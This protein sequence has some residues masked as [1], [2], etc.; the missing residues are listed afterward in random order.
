MRDRTKRRGPYREALSWRDFRA[1]FVASAVSI[2]GSVVSAVALTLLVY[3]RT[4]SP[5][6]S[7]LTFA[8]G[9]L[10]YLFGGTLLSGI[11][12]RVAPRRLL[13]GLDLAS[14]ALVAT[15]AVPAV[16]VAALLILLA[17]TSVLNSVASGARGGLVRAVVPEASYVPATS[18]LRIV[19]QAAQVL[20]NAVGGLLLAVLGARGAILVDA[21][22][23]LLSACVMRLGLRPH[24][25]LGAAGRPGVVR[26]SL[27]GVRT[28]FA[29]PRV[30]RLLLFG[31]L[32]PAFSVAPEALAASYVTRTGASPAFV[33]WWLVAL[34]VG[35]IAG[36]LL[37]VWVLPA[38]RLRRSVGIAAV[39]SLAPYLVFVARPTVGVAIP[40]LVLAGLGGMYSLGLAAL[41][42]E[43]APEEGFGRM[44]ALSTA[45]L[46]TIQGV[47]FAAAGALAEAVGPA[48]AIA[49]AGLCGILGIVLLRPSHGRRGI[50][51]TEAPLP[52]GADVPPVQGQGRA[53][54]RVV[55]GAG[56]S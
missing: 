19:V 49:I 34:P 27:R 30:R 35:M 22:S 36:D 13:V 5:L 25:I 2:T 46:M 44:M 40:L 10:P 20:G 32:V 47:G 52:L 37:G 45:G 24:A 28:I 7:S 38:D 26:D 54:T 12:D 16:P 56:R 15:M 31:W 3:E 6:L 8:V 17:A 39:A 51:D 48:P 53:A 4:S 21:G 41:V 55:G 9:F 42:R 43:A 1:I 18:L 50:P 14:M 11:V 23:F 33:G 29:N